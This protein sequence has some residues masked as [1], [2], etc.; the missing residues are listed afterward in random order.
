MTVIEIVLLVAGAL[1]F[2]MSFVIPERKGS[3][4]QGQDRLIGM[5]VDRILEEKAEEIKN[6]VKAVDSE[7]REEGELQAKRELERITNEKV[8]AI[9]DYS[10]VVLEDIEKSHK[11]VMFLYDML[12][13]KSTD[14]KNTIRKADVVKK[15]IHA[16]EGYAAGGPISG[17]DRLLRKSAAE[18][19]KNTEPEKAKIITE[20]HTPEDVKE[21]VSRLNSVSEAEVAASHLNMPIE[22]EPVPVPAV[23][24]EKDEDN[25]IPTE[26][27]NRND[28]VLELHSLG[29]SNVDIAKEM[30]MG[31]GEV[32]L[33]IDLF[34]A[35]GGGGVK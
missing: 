20:V 10:R 7:I 9:D 28:R 33:I 16:E 11:E 13:N 34:E 23:N 15:D 32:N 5:K 3:A 14:L 8:M 17:M 18:A 27:N 22:P 24:L 12:E 26:G 25:A 2:I 21:A 6:R 1:I 31:V 35:V 4:Q 19:A 30:N 29:K